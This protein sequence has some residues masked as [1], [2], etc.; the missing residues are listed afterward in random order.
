V[1]A[2]GT[3][4][5][6]PDFLSFFISIDPCIEELAKNLEENLEPILKLNLGASKANPRHFNGGIQ[7]STSPSL[8]LFK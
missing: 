5:L 2:V 6:L 7:P 1:T 4:T 3:I 8:P